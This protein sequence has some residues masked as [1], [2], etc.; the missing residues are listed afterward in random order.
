MRAAWCR[1]DTAAHTSADSAAVSVLEIAVDIG[2]MILILL[3]H[4]EA[5]LWSGPS[6][7]A[8]GNRRI[9]HD[10]VSHHEISALFGNRN[11]NMRIIRREL[12]QE[13]GRNINWL[14]TMD[15]FVGLFHL[16]AGPARIAFSRTKKLSLQCGARDEQ[17]HKNASEYSETGDHRNCACINWA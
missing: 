7:L 13:A 8:G 14:L 9:D 2:A 10:F 5:S 15:Q 11:A 17:E 1:I 4:V 3:K 16:R 6:A 12:C